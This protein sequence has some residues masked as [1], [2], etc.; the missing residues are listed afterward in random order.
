[1]PRVPAQLSSAVKRPAAVRAHATVPAR[2]G[3]SAAC[4]RHTSVTVTIPA[5]S[6]SAVLSARCRRASGVRC[7]LPSASQRAV[8]G[9]PM[10]AA[11][12]AIHVLPAR[13]QVPL[14][15]YSVVGGAARTDLPS[16]PCGGAVELPCRSALASPSRD[17][18]KRVDS[19]P[20]EPPAADIVQPSHARS[21]WVHLTVRF[22]TSSGAASALRQILAGAL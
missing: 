16:E 7:V 12:G 5:V 10:V 18:P 6:L 9:P 8:S 21:H 19:A 11:V 20:A 4:G 17:I 13:A 3:L 2:V 1:V 15:S 14:P 22:P